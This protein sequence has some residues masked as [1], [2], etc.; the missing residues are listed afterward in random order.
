MV[1]TVSDTWLSAGWMTNMMVQH[2]LLQ[3]HLKQAAF[4][5]STLAS[6]LAVGQNASGVVSQLYHSAVGGVLPDSHH[7]MLHASKHRVGA[8]FALV[9]ASTTRMGLASA[10]AFT[11]LNGIQGS[12]TINSFTASR[13]TGTATGGSLTVTLGWSALKVDI[14]EAGSLGCAWRFAGSNAPVLQ[15][16][17]GQCNSVQS[18]DL[19]VGSTVISQFASGFVVRGSCNRAGILYHYFAVRKSNK[20]P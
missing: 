7:S 1:T 16:Q 19:R 6:F 18:H 13:Y 9:L 17:V 8:S 4:S 14:F 2:S 12:A 5:F 20:A 10:G 15:E 3:H 11:K